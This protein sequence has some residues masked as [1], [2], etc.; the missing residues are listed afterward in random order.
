MAHQLQIIEKPTHLHAIVTGRNTKE[1][2]TGYLMRF[3]ET[4]AKNRG[5][6]IMLLPTVAEAEAWFAA[7]PR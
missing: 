3:A 5:V 7:R 2:V 6:P 1:N 4:V